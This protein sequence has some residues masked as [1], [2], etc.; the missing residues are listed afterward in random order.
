MVS[1]PSLRAELA[2]RGFR[3]VVAWSRGVD[4]ELFRPREKAF[5]DLPRP[6]HLCVGRVAIE[7]NLEAFLRLPLRG[8]KLVVGDGP[9]LPRLRKK[10]PEAVFAGMQSGVELARFYA[11]SD[12]FVFPSRTDTFGLVLLEALASGLPVA[13]HPVT[14]PLDVVT[15]SEVG[16]LDEDLSSA[17]ARARQLDPRACRRFALR[18]SW[19]RCADQFASHLEPIRAAP[20]PALS[21]AG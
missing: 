1:T 4:T 14:G 13:A 11:A 18:F 21:A 2:Q 10:F 3:N 5:L 20:V 7:K 8:T 16:A 19:E 17:I 12:V 6:I 15:S 9:D